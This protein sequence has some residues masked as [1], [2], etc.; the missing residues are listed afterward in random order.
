ME[1]QT[2]KRSA[3]IKTK[4]VAVTG[5][6]GFLGRYIADALRA[7][8]TNVIGV[9]RNPTRVPHLIKRGIAMRQADL[10]QRD[11]LAAAFSGA[12]MVV[13]N[14]ALFALENS[15]REAHRRA[16]VLGTENVLH[17]AFDA[18]VKRVVHISSV[19]VYKGRF[20][21]LTN[22]GGAQYRKM[23]RFG[24]QQVVYSASKA[25]S[26]QSA[27][28]LA[29]ELGLELTT[30]RPCGIYGG[31]DTNI[32]P[33]L[34]RLFGGKVAL[35]PAFAHIPLVYAGDV[36]NAV[37]SALRTPQT[38]G[39]AYNITGEDLPLSDFL[40]SWYRFRGHGPKLAIPIPLPVTRT[41]DNRLAERDLGWKNRSFIEGLRDMQAFQG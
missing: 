18:G 11:R 5:A 21:R 37:I 15:D 29:A 7:H 12:D 14:A 9:V 20:H 36:A 25:L 2:P 41:F 38:I 26:E 19:A 8:E 6:T 32:T 13:S 22:E 31:H 39:Q 24:S 23:P 4:T 10:G 3:Q 16:N 28:R 17:A 33:K 35:I 40:K 30:L 1:K 34:M 27:W